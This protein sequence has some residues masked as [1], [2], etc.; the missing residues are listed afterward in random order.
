MKVGDTVIVIADDTPGRNTLLRIG[1][2]CA[3]YMGLTKKAVA[4]RFGEN[5]IYKFWEE[6]LMVLNAS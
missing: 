4:V 3:F 6:E 2:I 1:I 5:D